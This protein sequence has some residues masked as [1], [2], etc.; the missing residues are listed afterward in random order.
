MLVWSVVVY[1]LGP[2]ESLA[3][4]DDVAMRSDVVDQRRGAHALGCAWH[5][6]ATNGGYVPMTA[7]VGLDGDDRNALISKALRFSRRNFAPLS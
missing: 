6:L 3:G 1:R 7:R 5:D 2:R 4:W